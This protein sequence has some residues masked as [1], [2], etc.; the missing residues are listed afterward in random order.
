MAKARLPG[1]FA[2]TILLGAN[3]SVWA[4]SGE[5]QPTPSPAAATA[6]SAIPGDSTK[7]IVSSS[8]TPVYP[9]G[10]AR[11]GV[12]GKVWIELLISETGDVEKADIISGQP[13]LARAVQEAMKKWKFKPYIRNGKPVKVSTKMPFDFAFQ[14]KVTDVKVPP[15]SS[16]NAPASPASAAGTSAEGS[17]GDVPQKIRVSSGVAQG[18]KLHDVQPIYPPEARQSHLQGDVILQATIGKDGLIHD[19]KVVKGDP[20]LADAA[21]GAVEQWRYRPYVIEGHPVEVETTIKV[22]F[23]M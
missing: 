7:L 1:K 5:P 16:A 2:L 20:V 6:S 9:M 11:N 13:D 22:V 17:G 15:D 21:K 8:P 10:A 4:Q 14:S 12:Q 3:F 19:L 23:H 18:L